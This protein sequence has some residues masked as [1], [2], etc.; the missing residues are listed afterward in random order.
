MRALR[1]YVLAGGR[2][3]RGAASAGLRLR[4]VDVEA[5]KRSGPDA[6]SVADGG[7]RADPTSRAHRRVTDAQREQAARRLGQAQREGRFATSD[8]YEQR[9]EQLLTARR[10]EDLDRLVGDLDGLVPSGIRRQLLRVLAQA[11]ADG[12]LDLEELES[13]TDRCLEPLHRSAA[14][15]LVGDLGY[16]LEGPE[17]RP[18]RAAAWRR[19]GRRIGVPAAVGGVVG[20]ALVAVPA[21]LDLPGGVAQWLPLA[22][23]TGAFSAVGSGIVTVAWRARPPSRRPLHRP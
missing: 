22:L 21:G 9:M 3:R 8:L 2:L 20:T 13:R 5:S 23:G 14:D 10:Q 4:P 11:H 17:R 15:T 6:G 7:P 16:R 1:S 18:A 19:V 12:R